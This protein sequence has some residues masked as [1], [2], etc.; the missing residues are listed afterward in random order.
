M[1]KKLG[2]LHRY[3]LTSGDPM[4]QIRLP[5]QRVRVGQNDQV[6]D[7][8]LQHQSS[9]VLEQLR[10]LKVLN[11]DQLKE[12][13]CP[14]WKFDEQYEAWIEKFQRLG[15]TFEHEGIPAIRGI[16]LEEGQEGE[17]Y[18]VPS[19]EAFKGQFTVQDLLFARDMINEVNAST[20]NTEEREDQYPQLLMTPFALPLKSIMEKMGPAIRKLAESPGWRER[21]NAVEDWEPVW[22]SWNLESDV[23]GDLLYFP[24]EFSNNSRGKTKCQVLQQQ[25]T[26]N[27]LRG[28]QGLIVDGRREIDR[29]TIIKSSGEE[30]QVQYKNAH[31]LL[32]ELQVNGRSGLSP[33]DVLMLYLLGAER[34]DPFDQENTVWLLASYL[35]S[36]RA[37]PVSFW[38]DHIARVVLRKD[39]PGHEWNGQGS[40][41]ARRAGSGR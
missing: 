27:P 28:Y 9:D 41:A 36:A 25:D 19:V 16:P 40:R 31:D 24:N 7:E 22:R 23:S 3:T 12:R 29:A 8:C 5:T 6:I 14:E 30:E 35:N 32:G 15:L 34:G 18:P 39:R 10:L 17:L 11:F 21:M 38:F 20:E 37:V 2:E 1:D 33:E 26:K 4:D 13:I